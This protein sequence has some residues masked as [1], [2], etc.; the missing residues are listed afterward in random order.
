MQVVSTVLVRCEICVGR[1]NAMEF[2]HRYIG[3]FMN[4]VTQTNP[5]TSHN[6]AGFLRDQ[7]AKTAEI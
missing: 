1:R 4:Q 7:F 5:W 6:P 3:N 2:S